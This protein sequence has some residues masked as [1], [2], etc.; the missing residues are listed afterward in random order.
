MYNVSFDA[1]INNLLLLDITCYTI[2]IWQQ[3]IIQNNQYLICLF[4]L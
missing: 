3:T 4:I 1:H 2:N